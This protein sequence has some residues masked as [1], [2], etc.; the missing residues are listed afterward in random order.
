[1]SAAGQERL[2]E[3]PHGGDPAAPVDSLIS[4]LGI[5]PAVL[6]ALV[7]NANT[8]VANLAK[9]SADLADIT[10]RVRALVAASIPN[11][12]QS[13]QAVAA[14]LAAAQQRTGL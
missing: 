4:R 2:I 12:T 1:M 6:Q 7:S 11:P 10:G 14:A 5:D 13:G 9:A 8:A 3:R